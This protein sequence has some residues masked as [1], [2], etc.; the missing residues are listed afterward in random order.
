[1]MIMTTHLWVPIFNAILGLII[2]AFVK[3][4]ENPVMQAV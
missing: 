3:K 4:E 2:A 1:M